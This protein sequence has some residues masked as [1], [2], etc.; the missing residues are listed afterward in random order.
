[1]KKTVLITGASSGFG[2]LLATRLHDQGFEVI[3][4][5]RHP[6]NRAGR[7]PFKLLRLDVTDHASIKFF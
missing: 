6:Q 2:L 4:T 3:G 7:F 1:M 5:S